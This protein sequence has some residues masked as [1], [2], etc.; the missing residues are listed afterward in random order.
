MQDC[1]PKAYKELTK[2]EIQQLEGIGVLKSNSDSKHAAPTFIQKKKTGNIHILMD[3]RK[4]NAMLI[5]KPHPL[6][7]ISDLLQKLTGFLWASTLDLSMG[8]YH[9]PI[10][11]SSQKLC[12]MVVPWGKYRYLWLPMGIKNSPDIFL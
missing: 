3:F 10:N 12:M 9:V 8:Y 1:I 7:K 5:C 6:P 2:T 4:L 11:K